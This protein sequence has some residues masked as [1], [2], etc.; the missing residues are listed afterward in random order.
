MKI[1]ISES[2]LERLLDVEENRGLL[3]K[4]IDHNVYD[5]NFSKNF[6]EKMKLENK[7][8]VIKTGGILSV[9]T[10]AKQFEE[11]PDIFPKVYKIGR[12]YLNDNKKAYM[13][14]ERVDANKF[15]NLFNKLVNFIMDKNEF[16]EDELLS[17][18]YDLRNILFYTQDFDD[19]ETSDVVK[20]KRDLIIRA[21]KSYGDSELYNF[22]VELT[23]LIKKLEFL[24]AE[25][26]IKTDVG[27]LDLHQGNFG[28]DKNGKIKCID[29]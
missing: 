13:V 7:D 9:F 6:L 18:E 15:I 8:F 27:I 26:K 14:I 12:K 29:F 2:Q 5:S 22:Y 3:G 21:L 23:Q 28:F 24:A 25:N 1:L 20:E 4:G 16:S 17:N 10:Y 19:G 11:F